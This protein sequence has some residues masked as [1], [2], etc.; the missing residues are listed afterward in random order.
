MLISSLHSVTDECLL[1]PRATVLTCTLAYGCTQ[2]FQSISFLPTMWVC[3][4]FWSNCLFLFDILI[5]TCRLRARQREGIP[6][7]KTTER[8]Q[9]ASNSATH[10]EPHVSRATS[11]KAQLETCHPVR[12]PSPWLLPLL[13]QNEIR[14]L[15]RSG[16][17]YLSLTTVQLFRFGQCRLP[18]IS[19]ARGWP[20]LTSPC[21]SNCQI[22]LCPMEAVAHATAVPLFFRSFLHE[23]NFPTV[24]TRRVLW[25]FLPAPSHPLHVVTLGGKLC[26]FNLSIQS[27]D[28]VSFRR[29]S[30][31]QQS[32]LSDGR[33]QLL[34]IC[35]SV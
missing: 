23:A 17:L 35:P 18:S 3:G 22:C 19:Q 30:C 29:F 10:G 20:C 6:K 2:C 14:P 8:R 11:S 28:V 4:T 1:N 31:L 32:C 24:S 13:V 15:I 26:N 12:P 21:F 25:P 34:H 27:P 7:L 9:V 33:D 5:E 16:P